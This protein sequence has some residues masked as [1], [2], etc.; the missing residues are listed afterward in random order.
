VSRSSRAFTPIGRLAAAVAAVCLAAGVAACDAGNNAP[1]LTEYHPQSD[2]ID[3]VAHGIEIRDAF[4]LGGA[5]GFT[6]PAGANAGFF[7]ALFNEGPRDALV[8]ASAPGTASSVT[9]PHGS[10]PLYSQQAVYLT[11]PEPRIIL[12]D[13]THPLPSGGSVR[14]ILNFQRA[15]NVVLNVPVLPRSNAYATFSPAPA[16]TPTP[17]PAKL[18]GGRTGATATASPTPSA[19]P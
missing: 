18:G 2:G 15:G 17:L 11:G 16:P 3:T 6:L 7:L 9:L 8:G 14:V 4:V 1:T 10:I 19:T 13:L 5:L 12:T